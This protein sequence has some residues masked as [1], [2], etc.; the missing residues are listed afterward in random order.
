MTE[1]GRI[2]AE[3]DK[4]AAVNG[5]KSSARNSGREFAKQYCKDHPLPATGK[6]SFCN[7]TRTVG[8]EFSCPQFLKPKQFKSEWDRERCQAP[9]RTYPSRKGAVSLFYNPLG[10][11]K[12]WKPGKTCSREFSPIIHIE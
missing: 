2:L 1:L 7:R 10:D 9:Q 6:P 11:K 8:G 5:R 3:L 4:V 12:D